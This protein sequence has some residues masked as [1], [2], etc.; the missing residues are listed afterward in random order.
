MRRGMLLGLQCKEG[1]EHGQETVVP[2]AGMGAA[3]SPTRSPE[4]VRAGQLCGDMARITNTTA[5]C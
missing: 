3:A 4:G 2:G 1:E 5:L